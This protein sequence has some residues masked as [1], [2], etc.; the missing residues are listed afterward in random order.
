MYISEGIQQE[1]KSLTTKPV[2]CTSPEVNSHFTLFKYTT[3]D[4]VFH[5]E[6]FSA[7]KFA[8]L[9]SGMAKNFTIWQPPVFP[10]LNYYKQK[11][12]GWGCRKIR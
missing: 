2:K 9:A 10:L 3:F 6:Y 4:A 5:P 12:A 7:L 1:A 8:F 11:M